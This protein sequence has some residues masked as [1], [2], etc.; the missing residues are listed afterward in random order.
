MF[1]LNML[2]ALILLPALSCFL[3]PKG[4]FPVI[5][6]DA[7]PYLAANGGDHGRKRSAPGELA[8]PANKI[9]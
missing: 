8:V 4:R 9:H 6:G 5:A 2:G 7:V 3:L 1:L